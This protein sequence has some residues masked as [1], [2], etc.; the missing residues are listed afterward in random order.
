MVFFGDSI[1]ARWDSVSFPGL[2]VWNAEIAPL[3]AVDFGVDGD[4]TQNLIW[5]LENGELD[6]KPKVAVVL[7]GTN[8]LINSDGDES[9]DE[10][11]AGITA[12]V[13]TIQSV[14]PQTKILLL[15]LLPRS[16]PDDP[17]R[18]E[19][20][21]V[22]SLIAGLQ[23]GTNILYAD[24]GSLFLRPDG[25]IPTALLPDGLHPSLEGY[26]LM[27]DF[28]QAPIDTLL[29]LPAPDPTTYGGPILVD[30]PSNQAEVA[31]DS[32]GALLD[33][34]PPLAFDALDPDPVVT[35]TPPRGTVLPLGT[36]VVTVTATDRYG[37]NA[38]ASFTFEVNDIPVLHNTPP[39]QS[40]SRTIRRGAVVHFTPPTATDVANPKIKVISSI[41]SGSI[42]P[43]GTTVVTFTATG[44]SGITTS[45][46]MSVTV[47]GR[48]P[49]TRTPRK[50]TTPKP[51]PHRPSTV[52]S[53][54]IPTRPG[55]WG[56]AGVNPGS[57]PNPVE[58]DRRPPS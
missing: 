28:V 18:G 55:D 1:T 47:V 48:T 22:N 37:H 33:F 58:A 5:R 53:H 4:R 27:A 9:P 38:S 32:R 14:S 7:I 51:A 25:S 31:S 3:S 41:P 17:V 57:I 44:V 13:Q 19:I 15:G 6:G 35:S 45:T 21:Q 52:V 29:G 49:P 39:S 34:T 2:P 16:T 24:L 54:P 43:V 42:F 30:M 36:T 26:Q 8:N 46:S 10:T 12:V 40:V 50:P 23:D 56:K 11:A 20:Q